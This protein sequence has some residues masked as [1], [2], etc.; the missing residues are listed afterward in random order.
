MNGTLLEVLRRLRAEIA[1]GNPPTVG[2]CVYVTTYA[3]ARHVRHMK[4]MWVNWPMY[5]G[6]IKF[7]VPAFNEEGKQ[8]AYMHAYPAFSYAYL[9]GTLWDTTDHYG[10]ARV[11]LLNWL[12]KELSQ[13]L[14]P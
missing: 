7:P 13:E 14:T 5:S 3:T 10:A 11:A 1:A 2:M 9:T 4:R 8:L 12:V 6:D